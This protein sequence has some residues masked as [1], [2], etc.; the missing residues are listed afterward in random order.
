MKRL[1]LP[2]ALAALV[3]A[4]YA[5]S[6]GGDYLW[7]D[8]L[9]LV[10]NRALEGPGALKRIWT[11]PQ[12]PQY[13][14]LV[15]TSFWL[16]RKLWGLKPSATRSLNAVLHAADAW[17]FGAALAAL[18]VPGAWAAPFLF[19]LHPVQV[20][21]VAWMAERKNLLS[22]LFYLL[23]FLAYWSFRQ[24]QGPRRRRLYAV[25]L[26]L[27][28]CALW[29]KTVTCSLP[30]AILLC[31]AWRERRAPGWKDL[32]PLLPFFALGAGLGALT[33]WYETHRVG[34]S[35]AAWALSP[36]A[37]LALAGR[38]PW[39]YLGKLLWPAPLI[40]IYPRWVIA[41]SS[42]GAWLPLLAL[43]GTFAALWAKRSNE[44]CRAALFALAFF[45][46]TL[47]PALGFFNVYPFRYSFVADHFQ[48][49]ASL[50]PIALAA[51]ALSLLPA[52][53]TAAVGILS[54]ALFAMTFD[55]SRAFHGLEGLWKDTL[56]KNPAAWIAHNNLG[57]LYVE[58][59][60][61]GDGLGHLE[62][63][64]KL[65][66]EGAETLNNIAVALIR[67]GQPQQAVKI[68]G[69]ALKVKPEYL[70]ARFNLGVA[71]DAMNLTEEA[72]AQYAE[73]LKEAPSRSE[74]RY[75][76][77]LDMMR[78]GQVVEALPHLRRV[79]AEN[80]IPHAFNNLGAAL[81]MLGRHDE[82]EAEFR[83]AL[84]LDPRNE[85]AAANL[86]RLPRKP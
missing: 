84:S 74:A 15:F 17:L 35:G 43:L 21:T 42:P 55:R 7:D 48:Y 80:P 34:A 65:N 14:P 2:A 20:E 13:Y 10:S 44:A 77:A 68:L 67:I 64:L 33:V 28:L 76:L 83:R 1:L 37:R 62:A 40:F 60:R 38:V 32:K 45:V 4:A 50:G 3:L 30:A 57:K 5:P 66:P 25:S 54:L 71:L 18:G 79:A 11:E 75:N 56:R 22:T 73:V 41:P 63:A 72:A 23:A 47:F 82:A 24:A 61:I 46:L 86:Q 36:A 85:E 26:G 81:A 8:D 69:R 16:E 70:D 52:G 27:F 51:A 9:Y 49:L 59:D 39:F 58:A 29:S 31:I 78:S 53:R 12:T 6:L 19:A